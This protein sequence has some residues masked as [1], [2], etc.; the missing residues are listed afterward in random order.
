MTDTDDVKVH[1]PWKRYSRHISRTSDR[2]QRIHENNFITSAKYLH[3]GAFDHP[4]TGFVP[5]ANQ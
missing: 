2:M 4:D 1:A 5:L 3:N